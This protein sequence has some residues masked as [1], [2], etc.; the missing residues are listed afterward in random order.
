MEK[1]VKY[2][3]LKDN[4]AVALIFYVFS[5]LFTILMGCV[6]LGQFP[7][8]M[9]LSVLIVHVLA[10][11]I[12][13]VPTKTARAIVCCAL[14]L[15]QAVIAIVNDVLYRVTGEIFTISKLKLASEATGAFDKSLINPWTIVLF[16]SLYALAVFCVF[17]SRKFTKKNEFRVNG[18]QFGTIVVCA[19]MLFCTIGTGYISFDKVSKD[20]YYTQFPTTLSYQKYGYYGFYIANI[21]SIMKGE[22]NKMSEVEK[23]EAVQYFAS[24]KTDTSNAYTGISQ[25][26]NVIMILAESL[27][28]VAIDEYFTPHLYKLVY[29]DGLQFANYHS[30]NKTNMSE[31]FSLM[32]TYSR[33]MMLATHDDDKLANIY[34][35]FS[36]ANML[37]EVYP[38]IQTNYLHGMRGDYYKRST[39]F[40]NL[41]FDNLYF[42]DDQEEAIKQYEQANGIE[43]DWTSANFY[44][45]VRDSSFIGYNIKNII[46]DTGRFISA[47]ATLSTHGTY[48]A[49]G[50]NEKNYQF[51]TSDANKTQLQAVLQDLRDQGYKPDNVLNKFL[52]YKAAVMDLDQTV[53]LIFDRLQ[54]TNNL[55]KTTLVIY[56]DHNAYYDY[57]SYL[58]RDIAV[59]DARACNVKAYNMPCVIYDQKLIAKFK[60]EAT[61]T[62]GAVCDTFV[63]VADIY[64]TVCNILGFTYNTQFCYGQDMFEEADK[65]FIALKDHRYIFND[66]YYFYDNKIYAVDG[67]VDRDNLTAEEEVFLQMVNEALTKLDMQEKL[68]KDLNTFEYV[69][70]ELK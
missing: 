58:I 22:N 40:D 56:S 61:Y 33:D 3:N 8:M 60:G 48:Q 65:L 6:T 53:G 37:K 23:Q 66:K 15:L 51:L 18:R 12:F 62:G 45:F 19:L 39:T 64:P 44:D 54:E 30:E 67:T 29:E 35:Q 10:F 69:L 25:D 41:G 70:Q 28:W 17:F 31:G 47:Y 34:G 50:S 57:V 52:Y 46:P 24:G 32:G 21:L 9:W 26:N 68:W 13:L 7:T 42:A 11:V 63:S 14:L 55:D 36:L 49:R 5:V 4:F 59:S 2:K 1:E 43:Y 16:L 38:D 27:D 20:L